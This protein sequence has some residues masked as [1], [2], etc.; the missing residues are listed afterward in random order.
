V[1]SATVRE[2]HRLRKFGTG[3]VGE[4]FGKRRMKEKELE[5]GEDSVKEK[6]YRLHSSSN[7]I[8]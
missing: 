8:G 3:C 1:V 5:A 7:I 2:E 4:Y 6:L